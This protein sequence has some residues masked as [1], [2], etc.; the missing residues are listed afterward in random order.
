MH[1]SLQTSQSPPSGG[2]KFSAWLGRTLLWLT[3]WKIE[4]QLPQVPK[5]VIAVAPHTSNWDFFLGLAVLFALKIKIRF[6]GK[7]SIFVPVLKQL[8]A[9]IGGMPVDR[10]AP[11]GVVGQVVAEFNKQEKMILAMSPEG[12]RSKIY[13]WKTGFLNIAHQAKVP[14]QLIGFDFLHKRVCIG[15][16]IST[17]GNVQSDLSQVYQYFSKISAKYPDKVQL[18]DDAKSIK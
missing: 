8:L 9:S 3:G 15:P 5:M 12:T 13:P 16:L 17:S 14:V 4:G 2:N 6:L 10:S 18:N 1:L 11:H 7:H